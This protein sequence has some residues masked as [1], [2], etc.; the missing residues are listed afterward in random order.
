M[1]EA[2]ICAHCGAPATTAILEVGDVLLEI[3]LCR[4]HLA[5]LLR[6]ARL[7]QPTLAQPR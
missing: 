1:P 6:G 7:I 2:T 3:D 4:E 5:R